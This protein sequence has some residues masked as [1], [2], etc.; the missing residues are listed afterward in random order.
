MPL[1]HEDFPRLPTSLLTAHGEFPQYPGRDV[2]SE[3]VHFNQRVTISRP[4]IV[5]AAQLLY[6]SRRELNGFPIPM[7]I[8][9]N[10]EHALSLGQATGPTRADYD[11]LNS[12]PSARLLDAG[13]WDWENSL[14]AR[15]RKTALS[16]DESF[17]TAVALSA[18]FDADW[19]RLTGCYSPWTAPVSGAFARYAF[20]SMVGRWVGRMLIPDENSYMSMI[21]N[22]LL[23]E[24][25]S[26]SFPFSTMRPFMLTLREYH[27]ISPEEP[28][29]FCDFRTA[30]RGLDDGVLNAYLPPLS[31]LVE[32]VRIYTSHFFS[33]R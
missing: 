21:Q 31:M 3:I 28:V 32:H 2:V 8:P 7:G 9:I 24:Y 20:G 22:P 17:P 10:R 6:F 25:F 27:C 30:H 12:H 19:E 13:N 18:R 29:D 26:E 33:S 15:E 23:P 16:G 11:E 5:P 14:S 1:I 4:Q